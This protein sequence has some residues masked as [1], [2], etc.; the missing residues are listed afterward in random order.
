MRR[1][2]WLLACAAVAAGGGA[3]A[4]WTIQGPSTPPRDVAGLE[5]N[6]ERGAYVARL[7][8]C[9]ACHTDAKAG[10]A[11][12]AGGVRLGTPFGTFVTPNI[13][14]HERDG[15]GD[16]TLEDF[17]VAMTAGRSPD[18]SHYFPSFPY[19]FYTRLS[20]Q[21]IVDLWAAV[22]SVPSVEGRAPDH[23][24]PFPFHLRIGAALWQRLYL[25]GATLEPVADRSDA[26]ARGRYLALGP[27]HC[28]A[29]HTPRDAFGGRATDRR[30]EGG[31]A[32]DGEKVPAI[33]RDA[34]IG[35]GWTRDDL[36]Y[37][38]QSGLMPDGDTFGGS[39][40]EVVR[41]GTRYWSRADREALADYLFDP[42]STGEIQ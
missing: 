13:T 30:F 22:R 3:L 40:A 15:I 9:I 37:A 6:V 16:W 8:G 11:V 38:L 4:V 10:G 12:L 25:D 39:M 36:V 21:D 26:W 34:L 2:A 1:K 42:A 19:P 18:G 33:T 17:A 24:L 32:T 35:D 20:D 23:E 7:S 27:A 28:G 14:P 5:G 41:D 29:C 31:M